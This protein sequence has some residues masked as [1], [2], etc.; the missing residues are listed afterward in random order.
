MESTG[1]PHAVAGLH[2]WLCRKRSSTWGLRYACRSPRKMP[3]VTQ[4]TRSY[5]STR[6]WVA[7][8]LLSK[9]I[10]SVCRPVAGSVRTDRDREAGV[11]DEQRHRGRI[12]RRRAVDVGMD[13]F[14][15]V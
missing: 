5:P 7:C 8:W 13:D 12:E 10:A 4:L 9:V 3:F 1:V 14:Q 15:R 2:I 11:V 6:L